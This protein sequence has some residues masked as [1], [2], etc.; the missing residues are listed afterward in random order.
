MVVVAIVGILAIGV[1][2]MF[3]DPAVK[4]KGQA[5][6]ILGDLNMA[7]SE[8]VNR[9]TDVWVTFL[10]GAAAADQ[11]GYQIWID[12]DDDSIYTAGNDTLIRET[13]FPEE[14]QFYD[15]DAT[16]GPD[17]IPP[18][19]PDANALIMDDGDSDDDGIEFDGANEFIF[20]PMGT[21]KN[22]SYDPLE[23]TGYVL[24]YYP[25]SAADHA[26]MRAAPYAV[27]V[28]PGV[29]SIRISRWNTRDSAWKR[30]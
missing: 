4:V 27:A 18:P 15:I 26:N 17:L 16:D 7:R 9:N 28:L 20:T 12:E 11:D 3:A 10:P 14:V 23:N 8:A 30:K 29:G 13:F 1:V 22:T 6:T 19:N 5:F 24:I 2:F 21:A 25:V